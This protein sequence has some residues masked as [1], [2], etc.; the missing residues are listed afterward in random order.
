[1]PIYCWVEQ[2]HKLWLLSSRVGYF[3]TRVQLLSQMMGLFLTSKPHLLQAMLL[4]FLPD[5]T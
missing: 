2:H 3:L 5:L 1:M 4:N